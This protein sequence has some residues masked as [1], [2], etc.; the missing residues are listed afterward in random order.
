LRTVDW[1]GVSRRLGEQPDRAG[2]VVALV[3]CHEVPPG[4]SEVG[5]RIDRHDAPT[6]RQAHPASQ[7]R[8]A[9]GSAAEKERI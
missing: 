5:Q 3:V 2:D 4:Q 1:Q 8:A 6:M 9:D 7:T